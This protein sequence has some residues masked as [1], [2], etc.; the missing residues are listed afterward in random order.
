MKKILLGVILYLPLTLFAQNSATIE[1]D[2]KGQ[3]KEQ[4]MNDAFRNAVQQAC[5]TTIK[6]TTKV[7]NYIT[8]EDAIVSNAQGYIKTHSIISEKQETN[9][10][11]VRIKA[12]VS[13]DP[14]KLDAQTLSQFVGGIRFLVL[15]DSRNMSPEEVKNFEY[16]YERMNEK[17]IENKIRYIEKSRF[18]ALKNEAFKILG[19]DTSEASYVQK[20]GMFADA[21]FLIFIKDLSIRTEQKAGGLSSTKV[22]IQA[23]AYDNCTAEGLGTVVFEGE[24]KTMPDAGEAARLSINSSIQSGYDRLMNFFNMRVGSWINGAPFELRFYGMGAPRNMR[25]LINK[26]KSDSEFGGEMEPTMTGDFVKLNITYKKKPYDMYNKVLD[27]A[28]AIPDMKTKQIDAKLLYGRQISFA[29]LDVPVKEA[30]E[31]K[32]ITDLK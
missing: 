28:D 1:V 4:A 27:F 31:R 23:K 21:E 18:E 3:S 15:Y 11:S 22:T 5:G 13:L 7:E 17:L 26:L 12:V 14:I 9:F 29:P 20:L 16:A 2:G 32:K 24:W 19:S 10:Y 30:V 6:A 25:E 8:L